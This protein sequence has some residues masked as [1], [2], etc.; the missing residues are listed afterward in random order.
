LKRQTAGPRG[1][2]ERFHAPVVLVTAAVEDD[3]ADAGSLGLAGQRLADRL[4][5]RHV[6]AL[7]VGGPEFLAA[8]VG[9][10]ERATGVVVD[11]LGV[12]VIEAPEHRQPWPPG[13]AANP[14][15][16]TIV[17]LVAGTT[18]VLGDHFAPAFLPTF[19]RTTSP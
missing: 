15:P 1:V 5:R 8:A 2:G 18:L 14:A 19:L 3:L 16:Q 13:R 12:D 10:D 6:A 7:R 17:P 4:R 11:D 9:R